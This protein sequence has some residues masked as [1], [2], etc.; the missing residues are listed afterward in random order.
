MNLLRRF[1]VFAFALALVSIAG[2]CVSTESFGLLVVAGALAAMSWYVTEGPRGRVLPRWVSN[3]LLLAVVLNAFVDWAQQPQDGELM[4]VVGRFTMWLTIIKLYEAKGVRDYTQLLALTAVLMVAG[5]LQTVQLSFA[6]LLL[7]YVLLGLFTVLL[8]QLHIGYERARTERRRMAPADARLVPPVQPVAGRHLG[9]AFGALGAAMSIAGIA[10]SIVVFVLFPRGLLMVDAAASSI[11]RRTSGFSDEVRLNENGRISESRREVFTVA[12]LDPHGVPIR[13]PEP[14]RLRGAVLDTYSPK[15]GRW[16][17]SKA[18]QLTMRPVEALG[19]DTFVELAE[20]PIDQRVQTFTQVVTMRSMATETIFSS[21]APVAIAG[22]PGRSLSFE[23][24]TLSLRDRR[25]SQ[26]GSYSEYRVRVQPFATP[27]AMKA[28]V[29]EAGA[30]HTSAGF[31]GKVVRQEAERIL[32]EHGVDPGEPAADVSASERYRHRLAVARAI[33]DELRSSR[34]RYTTDLSDFTLVRGEDPITLFL[35]RYRFG[36]CEHF[37]SAMA[38]L[39]RSVG[40]E[41]RLVTGFIAMEYDDSAQHYIVRESNAHA[42]V[43]VRSGEFTWTTFDPTPPDTLEA[44]NAARRSW[45]DRWRWIY[46]RVEFMWNNRFVGFDGGTQATLAQRVGE[47]WLG[48]L[49]ESI[50]SA[51]EFTRRVNDAFRLGP[52]GYIWLGL[53]GLVAVVGVLAVVTVARRMARIRQAIG[54][55]GRSPGGRGGQRVRSRLVRELGFYV[56]ALD[57]LERAGFPKPSW[58]SPLV[59][60]EHVGAKRPDVAAPLRAVIDRFYAVRYGGA[61]SEATGTTEARGLVT[62]LARTLGVRPR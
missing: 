27:E 61:D 3:V 1:P 24:A 52:A 21:Y 13:Y 4:G 22:E 31:P 12:M 10:A 7:V 44:I 29:G 35:T 2:F 48:G 6:I 47:N 59:F 50:E 45:V 17:T 51:K 55:A 38:A 58:Q 18:A 19:L 26:L 30:A 53:V 60:T 43:E 23:P 37:A 36:H 14:L 54:L 42:W 33:L 49:R 16:V 28:L 46:D 25:R 5:A 15:D 9:R 41:A 57:V 56:D 40:V 62:A 39:C 8:F 32:R 34:F 11:A 20:P